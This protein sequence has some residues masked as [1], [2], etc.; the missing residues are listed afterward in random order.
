VPSVS[1][2]VAVTPK[3]AAFTSLAKSINANLSPNVLGIL[4]VAP[5]HLGLLLENP[6]IAAFP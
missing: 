2:N 5:H 3:V 4:T 6:A 1:A